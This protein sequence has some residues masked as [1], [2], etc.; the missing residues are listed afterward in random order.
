MRIICPLS[1]LSVAEGLPVV[2]DYQLDRT[3]CRKLYYGRWEIQL[4]IEHALSSTQTSSAGER[5]QRIQT[6]CV[7]LTV[8]YLGSRPG[9]LAAPCRQFLEKGYVR[10]PASHFSR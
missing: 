7:A 3:L 10:S 1:H 5:L 8:F 9:S 2:E 4:M 6:I